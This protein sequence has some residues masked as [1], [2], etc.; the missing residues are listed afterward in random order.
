MITFINRFDVT[1]SPA[2]FEQAFD[3]TSAFFAAQPGFLRHRLLHHVEESGRYVNV[4]DWEDEQSFRRA[5]EQPEFA[6]HRT[7]LRAL[8]SSE[9]GLYTPLLE[10]VSP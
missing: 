1:G 10:R 3:R 6:A 8:S 5:L 9:P 2:E 4:A 7:A